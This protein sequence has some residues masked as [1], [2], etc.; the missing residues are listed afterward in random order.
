MDNIIDV[1]ATVLSACVPDWKTLLKSY[2][3][4]FVKGFIGGAAALVVGDALS[5]L[6]LSLTGSAFA[7]I[8]VFLIGYV[9]TLSAVLYALDWCDRKLP[10]GW[11]KK[12]LAGWAARLPVKVS[13]T[14]H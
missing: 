1:D 8:A 12:R 14:A 13:F 2:C 11:L 5:A 3:V 4:G 10:R 7:A 6:A 9:I